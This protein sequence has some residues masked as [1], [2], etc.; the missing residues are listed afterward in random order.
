MTYDLTVWR[1]AFALW[2]IVTDDGQGVWLGF[3]WRRWVAP[4]GLPVLHRWETRGRRPDEGQSQ[5]MAV[6]DSSGGL[7]EIPAWRAEQMFGVQGARTVDRLARLLH[8]K[9][10]GNP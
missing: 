10:R 4:P 7:V 5:R 2:P 1:R 3:Y 6:L 9:P 8:S